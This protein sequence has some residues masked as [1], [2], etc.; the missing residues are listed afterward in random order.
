[1]PTKATK[2]TTKA[3]RFALPA[4]YTPPKNN[5]P[6]NK[7]QDPLYRKPDLTTAT[8]NPRNLS[9][10]RQELDL[11]STR[12]VHGSEKPSSVSRR[13]KNLP[14]EK[15]TTS[16]ENHKGSTINFRPVGSP[17][18][19][20]PAPFPAKKPEKVPSPE[21]KAYQS[22]HTLR[23]SPRSGPENEEQVRVRFRGGRRTEVKIAGRDGLP[24][25]VVKFR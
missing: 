4:E 8:R 15:R 11:A 16:P 21:S 5:L 2:K 7:A 22:P 9:N 25:L 3:V 19:P 6:R 14:Q 1:M 18:S 17:P 20:R 23:R 10:S 12:A 24:P 13:P